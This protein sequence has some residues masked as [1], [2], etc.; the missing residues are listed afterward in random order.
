MEKKILEKIQQLKNKLVAGSLLGGILSFGAVSCK[1]DSP[2]LNENP[3]EKTE[4]AVKGPALKY[5]EDFNKID[6]AVWNANL[7]EIGKANLKKLI[8]AE[9]EVL[10]G[11]A[12]LEDFHIRPFYCGAWARGYGLTHDREGNDFTKTSKGL[13]QILSKE[14]LTAVDKGRPYMENIKEGAF[15]KGR[16][17]TLE[18]LDLEVYPSI[19]R[20]ITRKLSKD[21]LVA[22]SWFVYNVGFSAFE[23]S[24]FLKRLNNGDDKLQVCSEMMRFCLVDGK[25]AYGLFKRNWLTSC[26]FMYQ[27]TEA[28]YQQDL[29]K[30]KLELKKAE[31]RKQNTASL[32]KK[33]KRL[34]DNPPLQL[35]DVLL[36]LKN[37]GLY[38]ISNMKM[39]IKENIPE[40]FDKTRP[41]TPKVDFETIN[42]FYRM[43]LA[44][45]GNTAEILDKRT[46][47]R[48]GYIPNNPEIYTAE[49][50]TAPVMNK[51]ARQR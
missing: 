31:S 32:E 30:A 8:A 37:G 41:F 26:K 10:L 33:I 3:K 25:P 35:S 49:K 36:Y 1:E 44:K 19:A 20:S 23:K 21:E 42:K 6:Y 38:N 50:L 40:V 29:K 14:F 43:Q 47:N 39:L 45:K 13:D 5:D 12:Y 48:L 46:L 7:T 11:I 27:E 2:S 28:Q 9:D 22:V 16:E 4:L 15:L 18:Y 17:E 34:E 51:A 24:T